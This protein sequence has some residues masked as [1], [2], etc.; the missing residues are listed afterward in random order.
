MTTSSFVVFADARSTS[1]AHDSHETQRSS[2][3]AVS[4]SWSS[5]PCLSASSA[6]KYWN[7]MPNAASDVEGKVEQ[8]GNEPWREVQNSKENLSRMVMSEEHPEKLRSGSDKCW[9]AQ[10]LRLCRGVGWRE[11]LQICELS[12][13]RKAYGAKGGS[14]TRTCRYASMK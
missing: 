3:S 1:A 14:S 9:Q 12:T 2:S 8:E 4:Q 10:A 5:R 6:S 13:S 11:N 7:F